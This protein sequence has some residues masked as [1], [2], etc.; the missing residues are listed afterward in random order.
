MGVLVS[1]RAVVQMARFNGQLP[2]RMVH[3]NR[4]PMWEAHSRRRMGPG[5]IRAHRGGLA[6]MADWPVVRAALVARRV[7]RAGLA[8]SAGPGRPVCCD[9]SAR[10]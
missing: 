7:V 1:H 5:M 9:Y 6:V 8:V 10:R 3:S 4:V 2:A